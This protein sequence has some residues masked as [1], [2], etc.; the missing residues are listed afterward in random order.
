M[1]SSR[2]AGRGDVVVLCKLFMPKKIDK[3]TKKTLETIRDSLNGSKDIID[4][5]IHD[6][7]DRRN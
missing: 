6:A 2:G 5:I 3:A 1:P 4:K 7:E